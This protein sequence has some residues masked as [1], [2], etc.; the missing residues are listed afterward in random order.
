MD[1]EKEKWHEDLIVNKKVLKVRLDTGADCNIISMKD[2][3]KQRLNKKVSKSHS[4]LVTYAGHRIPAK[5]KIMLTCQYK[6]KKYDMEFEVIKNNAP[7][8]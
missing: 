7:A 1:A 8:I 4:K 5:G 2:L 6:D 3:R